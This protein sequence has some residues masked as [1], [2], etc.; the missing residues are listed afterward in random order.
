MH[1]V[2]LKPALARGEL[3]LIG[4]TTIAEYRKYIEKDAALE[5]RFQPITVEEAFERS[6]AWRYYRELQSA[7]MK[8]HHRVT[9]YRR[10]A[11]GGSGTC[12]KRYITDQKSSGQGN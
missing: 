8:S 1:L 4:A 10:G 11:E 5:R 9:A 7:V 6:S 2:L 3:Q 12:R